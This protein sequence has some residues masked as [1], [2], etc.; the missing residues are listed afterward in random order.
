MNAVCLTIYSGCQKIYI[1]CEFW[2]WKDWSDQI[3]SRTR[4]MVFID[5]ETNSFPRMV[6]S[7]VVPKGFEAFVIKRSFACIFHGHSC[8]YA[9]SMQVLLLDIRSNCY[10]E[11]VWASVLYF[12]LDLRAVQQPQWCSDNDTSIWCSLSTSPSS[13]YTTEGPFDNKSFKSIRSRYGRDHS[14]KVAGFCVYEEH[15]C[16]LLLMLSEP[17]FSSPKS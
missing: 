3:L 8:W 11:R 7:I 6:L 14:K 12:I 17:V 10:R 15:S 13:K 9:A 1:A 4:W 16:C 5:T 2:R